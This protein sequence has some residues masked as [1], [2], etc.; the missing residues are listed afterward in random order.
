MP[1][2]AALSVAL[3]YLLRRV[4]LIADESICQIAKEDDHDG[5]GAAAEEGGQNPGEDQGQV[6]PTGETELKERNYLSRLV[7]ISQCRKY[8][9]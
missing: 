2:S 6:A 9:V 4:Q 3:A 7:V 1:L 8:L 5:H